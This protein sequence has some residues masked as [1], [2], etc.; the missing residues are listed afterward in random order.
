MPTS[1]VTRVRSDGF[2]KISASEFAAQRG[3]VAL[4]MRFHVG[5]RELPGVRA[6]ARRPIPLQ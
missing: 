2:S 5:G 6:F 1:K 4:G 3:V